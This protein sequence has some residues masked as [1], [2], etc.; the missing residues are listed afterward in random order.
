MSR[1][2][3]GATGF[4]ALLVSPDRSSVEGDADLAGVA[5]ETSAARFFDFADR[6]R[7]AR[8]RTSLLGWISLFLAF[9]VPPLGLVLSI[10]ARLVAARR[11]GWR[12]W[13]VTLAT[14]VSVLLTV[15][16]VVGGFIAGILG[17]QTAAVDAIV[18]ES[19]PFCSAL[20][21]TPGILDQAG[22]GWPTQIGTVDESIAAM[23][24]YRDR[25]TALAAIAPSGIAGGVETI[26]TV[27]AAVV[28]NAESTQ[29]VDRQGSLDTVTAATNVSGIPTY[30]DLYCR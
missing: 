3:G 2:S 26:A 1:D 25:W 7:P 28:D 21:E 17:T 20:A 10:V 6:A 30:A 27:A 29:S 9:V 16:M 23:T 24:E 4:D 11:H 8:P 22:Y 15:A 13:P 5:H 19:A 12:T 18:A 14:V